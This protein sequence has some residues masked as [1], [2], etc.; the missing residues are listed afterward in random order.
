MHFIESPYT[1]DIESHLN[2]ELSSETSSFTVTGVTV[3]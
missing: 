2:Q 1:T 3:S